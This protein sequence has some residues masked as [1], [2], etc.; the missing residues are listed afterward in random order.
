MFR[1][2]APARPLLGLIAGLVLSLWLAVPA[3]AEVLL[4]IE[5]A[6]ALVKEFERADLAAMPQITFTTAT[7]WTEGEIE[8][9]GVSLRAI[10]ADSGITDGIVRAIAL[11]DYAVEI[12]V[13]ELDDDAP[14]IAHLMN[15]APFSRREKGP[16]WIVYPY[17]SAPEYRSETTYGRSVWQLARLGAD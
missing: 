7:I 15:G 2:F 16:L 9:T 14:V 12:P 3:A 8:F 17:D 1:S 5:R 11:N 6:G 4:R 13:A 10:L